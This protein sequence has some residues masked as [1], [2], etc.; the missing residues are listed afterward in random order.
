MILLLDNYDS[1]TYN[2]LDYFQQSGIQPVV[3]RNDELGLEEFRQLPLRA[4]IVSPGPEQPAKAG[5]L[6]PILA[7]YI[8]QIP[9]FGICLGHQAIGFHYGSEIVRAPQAIHG[10]TTAVTC[11][12]HYLFEGIDSK[13]D[14]MRYHSLII[15]SCPK[16]FEVIA[17]TNDGI[18]LAMQH[19]F[20]PITSVQFHPESILTNSGFKIIQNWA[21]Y[22]QL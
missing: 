20:L 21:N 19:Q 12:P 7:H 17:K 16:D 11:I 18:N 5:L 8:E 1:F 13:I 14:V 9:V 4:L 15:K 6:M 2:L 22:H 3:M 10:K